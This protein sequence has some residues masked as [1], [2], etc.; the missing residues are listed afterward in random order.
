MLSAPNPHLLRA[1]EIS[2]WDAA[3]LHQQQH[4][5]E[6]EKKTYLYKYKRE[7]SVLFRKKKSIYMRV[8]A[9]ADGI[10]VQNAQ[11]LSS[12]SLRVV[13]PEREERG[14]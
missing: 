13:N 1:V 5:E 3:A 11:L 2:R 7:P 12:A 8:A 10:K 14:V 9:R 6:K 4:A